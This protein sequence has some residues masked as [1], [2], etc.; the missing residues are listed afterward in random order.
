MVI[1]PTNLNWVSWS[2]ISGCHQRYHHVPS[3]AGW[4]HQLLILQNLRLGDLWR[5]A[6]SKD[7]QTAQWSRQAAN[8]ELKPWD[9]W[10]HGK[11]KHNSYF[12]IILVV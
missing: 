9:E 7:K 6:D 11:K 10:S 12:P 1:F 2:R 4:N 3:L 8:A 5:Q